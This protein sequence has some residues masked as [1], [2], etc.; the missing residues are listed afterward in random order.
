MK[1]IKF[2]ESNVNLRPPEGWTD[3]ECNRL[4]VYHDGHGLWMSR[5]KGSWLDRL[6]FLLT[7]KLWLQVHSFGHPPVVIFTER[8]FKKEPWRPKWKWLGNRLDSYRLKKELQ[9]Q[10]RKAA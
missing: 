1:A 4:D 9:K 10:L 3:K 6:R 2:P 5:W 8:G 7:G